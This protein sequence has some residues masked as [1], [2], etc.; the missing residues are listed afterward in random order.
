MVSTHGDWCWDVL[1]YLL[2]HSVLLRLSA[3]K[4]PQP[5]FP[6]NR[7]LWARNSD[8]RFTIR[9]AYC[10]R[11]GQDSQHD[12]VFMGDNDNWDLLVRA[13]LWNI[14]LTRNAIAFNSMVEVI[15]EVDSHDAFRFLRN[16]SMEDGHCAIMWQLLELRRR[17]WIVRLNVIPRQCN[18]VVDGL[19]KLASSSSFEVISYSALPPSIQSLVLVDAGG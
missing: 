16:D 12:K 4:M 9:S 7:L 1:H 2:P 19:A 17:D 5:W 11:S 10:L 13:L 6:N 3:M 15:L 18:M 14:W 8:G